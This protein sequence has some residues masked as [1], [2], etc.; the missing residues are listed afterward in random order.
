MPK[1]KLIVV[2]YAIVCSLLVPEKLFAEEKGAVLEGANSNAEVN[3]D[4]D[5]DD[6]E[7]ESSDVDTTD[8]KD[9]D[10]I[11]VDQKVSPKST[12]GGTA[13]DTTPVNKADDVDDTVEY[14]VAFIRYNNCFCECEG[15]KTTRKDPN[16]LYEKNPK[17]M[18]ETCRAYDEFA[19]TEKPF[20]FG[21]SE[22][23]FKDMEDFEGIVLESEKFRAECMDNVKKADRCNRKNKKAPPA[24]PVKPTKPAN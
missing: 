6:L 24:T 10:G 15:T 4:K 5:D 23:I 1:L 9:S 19:S 8:A 12:G 21:Q 11:V 16:A 17:S 13:P 2:A 3:A 18:A 7:K 14:P 22:H 20:K